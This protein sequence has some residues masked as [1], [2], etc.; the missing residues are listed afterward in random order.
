MREAIL[1][2]GLLSCAP[3]L[4]QLLMEHGA[5]TPVAVEGTATVMCSLMMMVVVM[6]LVVV[7]LAMVLNRDYRLLLLCQV[8]A[9]YRPLWSLLELQGLSL[10]CQLLL[11][12]EVRVSFEDH[13]LR[14]LCN[15]LALG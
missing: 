3:T 9:R 4:D 11:H 6:V 8:V 7:V 2:T 10:G 1:L 15:A 13:G 5:A 14:L 12:Y